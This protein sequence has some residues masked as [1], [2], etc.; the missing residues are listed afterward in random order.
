MI[1]TKSKK[2]LNNKKTHKKYKQPK[3]KIHNEVKQ[4][5][6]P[7][8]TIE[9]SQ[10]KHPINDFNNSSNPPSILSE[11][12]LNRLSL[13]RNNHFSITFDTFYLKYGKKIPVYK[14]IK[15]VISNNLFLNKH[16]T[17]DNCANQSSKKVGG[18]I[19]TNDYYLYP[20]PFFERLHKIKEQLTNEQIKNIINKYDLS[21]FNIEHKN[22]NHLFLNR[23]F[24]DTEQKLAGILEGLNTNTNDSKKKYKITVVD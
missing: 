23:I 18:N 3:L 21:L 7:R 12:L 8:K 24:Q 5:Y 2:Y 14:K 11:L 10:K 22:Q 13:Q 9:C 17:I 4:H 16:N 1:K 19:Y 15:W 20:S 6:L